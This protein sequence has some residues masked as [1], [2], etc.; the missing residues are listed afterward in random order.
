MSP[1]TVAVHGL[2]LRSK[3]TGWAYVRDDGLWVMG[4]F[5]QASSGIGE[6]MAVLMLLRDYPEGELAV[7]SSSKYLVGACETWKGAWQRRGYVKG[8]GESVTNMRFV[9]PIHHALDREPGR[10][11]FAK[12]PD[13]AEEGRFPL[14]DTAVKF[15]RQAAMICEKKGVEVLYRA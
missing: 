10:V 9:A 5:V 1:V 3:A 6:L 13:H 2:H 15:A 14:H 11:E 12:V 4:G 8:D 7:Q